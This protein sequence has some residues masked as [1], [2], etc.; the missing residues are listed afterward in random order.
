M[1]DTLERKRLTDDAFL[2]ATGRKYAPCRVSV[3]F[4]SEL[5]DKNDKAA[6]RRALDNERVSNPAVAGVMTK[7]GY[8]LNADQVK[9]HRS[10]EHRCPAK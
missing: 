2:E 6:F 4:T 9:R 10:P 8:K 3:I 1:T 7:A 5:G